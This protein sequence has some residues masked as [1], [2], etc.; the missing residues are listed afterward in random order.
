MVG[1]VNA[2]VSAL[3][4]VAPMVDINNTA[5]IG[6]DNTHNGQFFGNFG[7]E[8]AAVPG[9]GILSGNHFGGGIKSSIRVVTFDGATNSFKNAGTLSGA[10][11]DRHLYPNYLGNNPGNQGRNHS[12]GQIIDNPFLAEGHPASKLLIYATTAKD[13]GGAGGSPT[14][15]ADNP[16]ITLAAWLT[17]VPVQSKASEPD[18]LPQD[19]TTPDPTDPDPTTPEPTDPG[20]SLGGCSTGGSSTGF[21][22]L[23]LLGLAAFI[24]R[25]R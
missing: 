1:V 23:L 11:H 4:Y 19:P 22:T 12:Q 20:T 18:P 13:T 25:R 16:A 7:T 5:L 9:I 14:T 3:T 24:R 15:Q 6:I 17:V 21:A 10:P 8:G 2:D